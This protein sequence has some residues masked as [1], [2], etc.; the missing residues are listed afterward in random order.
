MVRGVVAVVVAALALLV[1]SAAQA[2]TGARFGIQDD[3]WL[4]SGPGSLDQRLATLQALGAG[5]VRVTLRWDR[6]APTRP[7]NPRDPETYDWGAYGE[8]LDGLHAHGMTALVT[9]YGTP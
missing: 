6:V 3:A 4:L 1:S 2:S 9:L 7:A 8:A 5:V